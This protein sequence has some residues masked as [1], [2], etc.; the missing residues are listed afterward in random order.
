VTFRAGL[1]GEIRR[2]PLVADVHELPLWDTVEGA[3]L[4]ELRDA[5]G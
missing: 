4:F 2:Q 1:R 5:R 3:G